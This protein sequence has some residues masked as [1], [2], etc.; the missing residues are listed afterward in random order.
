MQPQ[1]AV[2]QADILAKRTFFILN[3][4]ILVLK[5]IIRSILSLQ[6]FDHCMDVSLVL[7][8]CVEM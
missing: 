8:N 7:W 1:G 4:V 5:Y 3:L 2:S 6:I